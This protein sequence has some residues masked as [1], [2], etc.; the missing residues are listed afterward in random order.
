MTK[1]VSRGAVHQLTQNGIEMF[2][3][4]EVEFGELTETKDSKKIARG[5]HTTNEAY[6]LV[7]NMIA[8]M[9]WGIQS[10]E[11]Q[12]QANIGIKKTK[13]FFKTDKF[14]LKKYFLNNQGS[15]AQREKVQFELKE[16]L[17]TTYQ[18][19]IKGS[20]ACTKIYASGQVASKI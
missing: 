17:E 6:K 10:T 20:K 5:K 14:I 11:K 4:P 8:N 3:F 19:M 18:D 1:A 2:F 12:E 15:S 9:G 13:I 7:E 16:K